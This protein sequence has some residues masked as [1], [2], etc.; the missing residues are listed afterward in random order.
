MTPLRIAIVG[1]RS[2]GKDTCSDYL[3][4]KYGCAKIA[5][6]TPMKACLAGGLQALVESCSTSWKYRWIVP[7]LRRA[8]REKGVMRKPMQE[9]GLAM[10]R[11]DPEILVRSMI[12]RHDVPCDERVTG[13]VVTDTRYP[14][15]ADA[16]RNLGFTIV[17]ITAPA[18][19]RKARALSRGDGSWNDD[20]ALHASEV[21]QAGIRADYTIDNSTDD[22]TPMLAILTSIADT[23]VARPSF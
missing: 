10:R 17:R 7:L 11:V 4:A 3:V 9:G 8:I 19:V 6:A 5:L 1:E 22:P 20:D 14:N 2:S 16:L 23:H 15:E 21:E 13:F 12:E 18:E